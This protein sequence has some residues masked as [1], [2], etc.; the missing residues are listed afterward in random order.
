MVVGEAANF[1]AYAFAPAIL[2]TPL[3]ALSIIVSAILAHI[4]LQEKLNMFGMLGCLL[5]ITGSLTIVL[6]A[7]PERHLGSVIEVFQLAMQPAFLGYTVFAVCV[8]IFLIFYVAPQ[9]GTSSIFVYLAI[10]SLAGSL[11]VMSCKALGIALKLTF[12]GDN[13]LLFG[14]TY[15][16]I[17]VVVACVMT[18]MNYLNKALDLFNTAIV[19]PVYYVMFT[20]LTI[21]ASIIMFRDVQSVEQVVTEACGFVTIVGGTFLLHSTKD[22]DVTMGDLN[23][24][25]KEKDST[26]SGM[27][28]THPQRRALLDEASAMLL[29][30]VGGGDM[31]GGN[32][33]GDL[34]GHGNGQRKM[35]HAPKR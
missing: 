4:V 2:V 20:L 33:A 23:R 19:S 16:C 10:C 14:E 24:M 8:I 27:L 26:L 31:E 22:L 35:T 12:Q 18:Q 25:L 17:M 6:H 34:S 11:S 32:N 30:P 1:A 9:H 5:C 21:L 3:G 28:A 29:H 7:P 13:Q 15:V